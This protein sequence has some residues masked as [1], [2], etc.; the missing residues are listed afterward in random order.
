MKKRFIAFVLVFALVVGSSLS[1]S[2]DWW[3]IQPYHPTSQSDLY[4]NIAGQFGSSLNMRYITLYR[5]PSVTALNTDQKFTLMRPRNS[6]D[7]SFV[8]CASENTKYA[9]NRNGSTGRAWMWDLT[10]DGLHDSAL[11]KPQSDP[12]RVLIPLNYDYIGYVDR[13]V[14]FDRGTRDWDVGGTPTLPLSSSLSE[15]QVNPFI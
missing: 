6:T 4:M 1:V 7:N 3:Y 2:A 8:L 11:K 15:V 9:I 10:A 12:G 5:V 14:Y 13:N